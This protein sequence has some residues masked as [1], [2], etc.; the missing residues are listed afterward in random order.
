MAEHNREIIA[1]LEEHRFDRILFDNIESEIRR[2]KLEMV[3]HCIIS[4]YFKIDLPAITERTE[5]RL[6]RYSETDIMIRLNRRADS[7]FGGNP[8]SEDDIMTAAAELIARREILR[9]R[10]AQVERAMKTLDREEK[11]VIE[12][13]IINR[14]DDDC[15]DSIAEELFMER[16]LYYRRRDTALSKLEK[17]LVI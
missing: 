9:I 13:G 16:K 11:R 7:L 17:V 4:D 14:T 8:V 1:R 2:L 15:A 10:I 3:P 6:R 5:K 12:R